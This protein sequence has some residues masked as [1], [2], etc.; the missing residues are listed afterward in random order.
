ML[1]FLLCSL[2]FFF[3]YSF[4]GNA[5]R[6]LTETVELHEAVAKVQ[7]MVSTDDTLLLVTADHGHTTSMAGYPVR[8]NPILDVVGG[9]AIRKKKEKRKRKKKKKKKKEKR[10]KKQRERKRKRMKEEEGREKTD[11]KNNE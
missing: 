5:Y 10:K 11:G 2:I 9:R 1:H 6:A 4:S 3:F 7:S 8:G